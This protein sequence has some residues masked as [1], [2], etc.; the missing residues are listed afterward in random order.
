MNSFV[1]VVNVGFF[2]Y[3]YA[4]LILKFDKKVTKWKASSRLTYNVMLTLSVTTLEH[5]FKKI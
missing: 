2:P 5:V 1:F 3:F 4:G